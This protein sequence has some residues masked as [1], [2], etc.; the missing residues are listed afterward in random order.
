MNTFQVHTDVEGVD[1]ES[2][3]YS[4]H[5]TLVIKFGSRPNNTE[6]RFLL[7]RED[8]EKLGS[9]LSELIKKIHNHETELATT[10]TSNTLN[11][12]ERA[13]D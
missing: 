10:L 12:K 6:I 1:V 2:V 5:E 7:S 9:K 13:D 11:I 3:I 8:G 4:T